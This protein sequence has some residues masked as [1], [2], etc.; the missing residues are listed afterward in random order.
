MKVRI[1]RAKSLALSD[2]ERL[3]VGTEP[4]KTYGFNRK[5]CQR[6]IKSLKSSKILIAKCGSKT[7]GYAIYTTSF[8]NGYYLKQIVVDSQY[9]GCG[10]GKKLMKELERETF[11]NK[12]ALYL[13]V[14]DFN[15]SAQK[16]YKEQGYSK[17]GLLRDYFLKGVH[18]ILLCKSK[19]KHF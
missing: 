1:I 10:F 8:L 5:S 7:L 14:S 3:V 2:C 18:E 6:I 9:R 11:K 19:G 12:K 13:C 15:R 16:F 4:F 17:I